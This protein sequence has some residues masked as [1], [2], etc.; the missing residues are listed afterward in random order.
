MTLAEYDLFAPRGDGEKMSVG[1]VLAG[2]FSIGG[3]EL[4]GDEIVRSRRRYTGC[5]PRERAPSGGFARG[6]ALR[7]GGAEY[8]VLA[9]VLCGRMWVLDLSRALMD[10]EV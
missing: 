7:R 1:T 3:T 4:S 5:I 8:R 6:M 9:A 10:G 2:V